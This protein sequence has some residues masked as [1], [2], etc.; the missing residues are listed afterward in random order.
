MKKGRIFVFG[1][2]ILAFSSAPSYAEGNYFGLEIGPVI[3]SD[4]TISGWFI[5]ELDYTANNVTLGMRFDF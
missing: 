2:F 4:S 3:L 1:L 5:D